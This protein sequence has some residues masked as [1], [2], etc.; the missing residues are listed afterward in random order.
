MPDVPQQIDSGLKMKA[1]QW[2]PAQ[3]KVVVNSVVKPDPDEGQILIKLASASLC[4]SDLMSIRLGG[5]KE[6]ITLGHEGAGYVEKLHPSTE[7]KGF[8]TGDAVGF[9]YV[10]NACFECRGCLVHNNHCLK[11]QSHVNGFTI[12]GFFSEYAV[13]DWQNCIKLPDALPVTSASVIFCAGVTCKFWSR[14]SGNT[15]D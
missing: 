4:H 12:P 3:G 14:P 8:K 6:P 2:D 13:V 7:G 10:Q 11:K 1:A 5:R 9:L 15:F